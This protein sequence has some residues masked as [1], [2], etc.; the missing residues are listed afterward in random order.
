MRPC[1]DLGSGALSRRPPAAYMGLM[2]E[3]VII[4]SPDHGEDNRRSTAGTA[5]EALKL[6]F[7]TLRA[8]FRADQIRVTGPAGEAVSHLDLASLADAEDQP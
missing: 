5:R 6:Y 4:G 8:G 3:Y 1:H 2:G 7:E